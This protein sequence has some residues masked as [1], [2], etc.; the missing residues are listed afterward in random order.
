MGAFV[1]L[2][3]GVAQGLISIATEAHAASKEQVAALYVRLEDLLRNGADACATARADHAKE[4]SETQ[5]VFD[6]QRKK[7]TDEQK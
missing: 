4:V 1:Q 6:E 7:L 2:A 5:T 3:L